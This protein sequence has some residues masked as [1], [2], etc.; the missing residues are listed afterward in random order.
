MNL[1]FQTIGDKRSASEQI[2]KSTEAG[3]KIFSG[4]TKAEATKAFL[5][6]L[7]SSFFSSDAY[8]QNGKSLEDIQTLAQSTDVQNNHNYMALLSN[9]MSDEDY[10]AVL[11]GGF[12]FGNLNSADTVTIVDKIKS[13]LLESGTVITGYND[14]LSLDKLE[15]IT[16]SRSF[17]AALQ[18]NFSENDIPVTTKNVTEAKQA[19][20]Q[21]SDI[22]KID[23]SAV[24][25]LVLND[26]EPTINNIY[27]A[28]HST[29]G[30]NVSGRGFYAQDAYGYYAKKADGLD[31]EQVLPQIEKIVKDAG[32]DQNDENNIEQAKW[33]IEEGIPLTKENLE[34]VIDIKEIDFPVTTELGAK[35]IAAAL[36]DG[37]EAKEANLHDPV[38]SAKKM[39][40]K[41]LHLEE[42]RIKMSAAVNTKLAD[43][44]FSIDLKP[45]EKLVELIKEELKNLS[46]EEAGKIIDEKTHVTDANKEYIFGMTVT[47]VDIIKQGPVDVAGAMLDRIESSSL[48]E[49][50]DVS[51]ELSQKYRAAQEEYEKM[52]TAP[53]ADLGDS[54]KKAF[55]NVDDILAD[56][57]KEITEENR[58]AVR[59]LGYNTLEINEE[60]FEKV[61][62]YDLRLRETMERL[63]PGAVLDFIRRG[64]NPLGMTIEE[65]SKGLD[66]NQ[67][68]NG[69]NDSGKKSDEKYARFLYKLEKNNGITDEERK[70][71][72]G[73]YRLFHNIKANDYKAI[74]DL[75]KTERDMTLGNLLDATRTQ[76]KAAK[77]IDFRVDEEFGGLERISN[78]EGERIDEQIESAFIFYKAHADIVYENLE[79]EKLKAAKPQNKTLLE[80]LSEKLSEQ[81]TDDELEKKYNIENLKHVRELISSRE[82][83]A[84]LEEM[85]TEHVELN[86]NNL[87]AVIENKRERRRGKFWDKAKE[88]DGS[89]K[90]EEDDLFTLLD[91]NNYEESYK[92]KLDQISEKLTE[93]LMNSEDSYIDVR[94]ITLM[95]KQISVM[96]KESENATFDVPV[97]IDGDSISMHIT[98]KNDGTKKSR[99]DASI[100]TFE[101]GFITAS[102]YEESGLI[103][104]MITTTMSEGIE[105]SEYLGNVKEKL[106]KKLSEK[107]K[108]LGVDQNQIGILY[109]AKLT[110]NNS[111]TDAKPDG[112]RKITNTGVLLKMAKAFIEAL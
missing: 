76:A 46:E 112:E 50:S 73:I 2:I 85:E 55:E 17:A 83:K 1:N 86:F 111:T 48:L 10:A 96:K 108:D 11:E 27:L 29:N 49:I 18:K 60:N 65:L 51:F 30:Q 4:A 34:A 94:A 63:K 37:K 41:R 104:G 23:D 64:K 77:G 12:D 82:A 103:K 102:L 87:E 97:E 106:C 16:G 105:E 62:A 45:I 69:Q 89:I 101:Y 52:E 36:A 66:Q 47:R 81:E 67:F 80:D 9:T 14:D 39:L 19:F 84:A 70:S 92:Q 93:T 32:L 90:K 71:F 28:Q 5:V 26:K 98:L 24:K 61:R 7:D 31:V 33:I 3:N 15:K 107:I 42:T 59:I 44:D 72:I 6:D 25:Y 53:R 109:G 99:M 58:R 68:G 8:A 20:E 22:E 21:I 54:I 13:V 91:E 75:L 43:K 35:A 56:L 88:F 100:Q 38:S 78:L 79:P 40:T 74:G 95:Q 57:G 110:Q